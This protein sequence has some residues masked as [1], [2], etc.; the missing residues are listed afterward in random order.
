MVI[1]VYSGQNEVY[2]VVRDRYKVIK[3]LIMSLR[4]LFWENFYF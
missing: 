3:E 1:V 2:C 4:L